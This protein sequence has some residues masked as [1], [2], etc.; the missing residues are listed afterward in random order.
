MR[1]SLG[2]IMHGRKKDFSRHNLL[3]SKQ[4]TTARSRNS[5]GGPETSWPT[6]S[7]NGVH[8][9]CSNAP[10]ASAT[11][12]SSAPQKLESTPTRFKV[13]LLPFH[14]VSVFSL[15]TR[16]MMRNTRSGSRESSLITV[17]RQ[18]I[19]LYLNPYAISQPWTHSTPMQTRCSKRLKIRRMGAMKACKVSQN[20]NG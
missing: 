19:A 16:W 18:L 14:C 12:S 20:K 17:T 4:R 10:T 7:T 6:C 11:F 2:N 15:P 9:S 5:S 3:V 1:K 8:F 13:H